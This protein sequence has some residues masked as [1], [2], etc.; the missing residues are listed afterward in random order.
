MRHAEIQTNPE[1]RSI[2]G[3]TQATA[4]IGNQTR[5]GIDPTTSTRIDLRC[6][7]YPASSPIHVPREIAH[8]GTA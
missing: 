4:F 3:D 8:R 5:D 1:K 7:H 6:D 2:S